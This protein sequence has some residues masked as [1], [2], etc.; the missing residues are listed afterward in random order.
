MLSVGIHAD[1]ATCAAAR[2][3]MTNAPITVYEGP[4]IFSTAQGWV[5][6]KIVTTLPA[7]TSIVVCQEQSIGL[8]LSRQKWLQIEFGGGNP[9]WISAASVSYAG[10]T[11]IDRSSAHG[12]LDLVIA[13]AQAQSTDVPP[14]TSQAPASWPIYLILF[15]AICG[16]MSAKGA[17]DW[18]Q[19]DGALG[20]SYRRE[21]IRAWLVS[22]IV[23]ASVLQVGDFSVQTTT[24]FALFV[25]WAFQNGF[26]W[27]TILVKAGQAK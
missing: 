1:A 3:G 4:P 13:T 23:F 12:I 16:G 17:F 15:L 18:M 22:P 24:K 21:T 11:S 5:L 25:C 10:M 26:F 9:G 6:A 19:Q 27:Q 7:H 20:K 8:I 14:A 2:A